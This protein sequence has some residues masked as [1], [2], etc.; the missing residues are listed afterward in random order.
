MLDEEKALKL[1]SLSNLLIES[2]RQFNLTAIT[3]E[4]E[5][6]LKH[7]VDCASISGNI[8]CR[9]GVVDVG[10]GAGFPSL[11]LAILRADLEITALDSTAK[12]ILFVSETAKLLNLANVNAVCARAEEYALNNRECFDVCT[13]RAVARMNILS[14]L[15]LPLVRVGGYFVA[16]KS[17]K[18]D[19]EYA[20]A[21]FG[22]DKLGAN[23]ELT[24]HDIFE[25]KEMSFERK[26]FVFKKEAST[27]LKFP[28]KYSQILKKPL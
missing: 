16:M 19:E 27:P 28:R 8:P 18:G 10:C 9:S 3:D 21:K 23:L 22:I 15:C 1:Y 14:E 7:F 11:P 25:W 13:S 6:M 24:Q 26:L 4:T 20:E 2:N 17:V 12:R 5:I